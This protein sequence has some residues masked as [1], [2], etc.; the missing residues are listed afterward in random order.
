MSKFTYKFRHYDEVFFY[1]EKQLTNY[2]IW[3]KITSIKDNLY[4]SFLIFL[5]FLSFISYESQ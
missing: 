3:N 4:F 5:S 1:M 2:K